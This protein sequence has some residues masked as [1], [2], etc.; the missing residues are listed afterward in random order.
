[1]EIQFKTELTGTHTV[2]RKT[3][4]R[5]AED[6]YNWR[7]G[8]SGTFLRQPPGYNLQSQVEWIKSRGAKEINYVIYDKNNNQK[9]GT[10]GIYDVNSEDRVANIGR[11]LLSDVYLGTSNPFG[12]EALLLTYDYLF[13]EMEF[14]KMTGDI[15]ATNTAMVKLQKFLGMKEEGF[16]EK[17][18][19]INGKEHD[20]HIMSIF[21]DQF[22]NSYKK[23]IA[24][25]LRSFN[26]D[27]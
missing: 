6:I 27:N 7:S 21:R 15:L 14:R 19:V 1:M 16:L 13:N 11:L 22:N 8:P 18:V 3:E 25:L 5:D 4:I 17:H 23:K 2:L 9:V 26:K 10:I 12:L 20:L 24:F